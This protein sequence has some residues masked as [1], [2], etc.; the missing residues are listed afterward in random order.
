MNELTRKDFHFDLPDH[1][2]AHQALAQRD[3]ARLMVRNVS[4]H[5]SDNIVSDLVDLLPADSLLILNNT[6][7]F[8]SRLVGYLDTGAK[9]EVF[10]LKTLEGG[11]KNEPTSSCQRF[12][13]VPM[14]KSLKVPF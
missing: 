9:V 4:G 6:K 2:V 7:V 14:T 5:L 13:V 8:P 3:S 11:S 12:C 10:L 1:L